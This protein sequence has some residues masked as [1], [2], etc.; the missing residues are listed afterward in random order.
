[1]KLLT[2]AA[3]LFALASPAA[4]YTLEGFATANCV[5]T[6]RVKE[7]RDLGRRPTVEYAN[8]IAQ[9]RSIRVRYNKN[10]NQSQK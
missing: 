5:G 6:P 7:E 4:A 3:T 2:I 9:W 8:G 1:M 10:E